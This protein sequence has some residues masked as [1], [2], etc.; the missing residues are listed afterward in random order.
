M[1]NLSEREKRYLEDVDVCIR[2][3]ETL[4]E[5][6]TSPVIYSGINT[7]KVSRVRITIND[8]LKKH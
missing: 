2:L 7:S 5:N 3:L 8:L 4:K 1:N 6:Y